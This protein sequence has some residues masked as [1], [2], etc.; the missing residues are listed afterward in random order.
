MIAGEAS[1]KN[2]RTV[3]LFAIVVF[4]ILLSQVIIWSG[5]I[6]RAGSEVIS[7]SYWPM[8]GGD[9]Q[10][11]GRSN[12]TVADNKGEGKWNNWVGGVFKIASLTASR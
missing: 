1:V 10:H 6:G 12:F 4:V 11:T 8:D 7:P 3:A 9:P 5:F 2:T